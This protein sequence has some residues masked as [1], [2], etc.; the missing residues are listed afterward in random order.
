[1]RRIAAS[2]GVTVASRIATLSEYDRKVTEAAKSVSEA[3]AEAR[4]LRGTLLERSRAV[5]RINVVKES[6]LPGMWIE[7]WKDGKIV[8]RAWIDRV[9]DKVPAGKTIGEYVVDRLKMKGALVEAV[10]ILDISKLG[11]QGRGNEA[12]IE[13]FTLEVKFK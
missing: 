9:K 5:N 11:A 7:S 3:E 4:R 10:K 8:V 2:A 6:L 13:Q 1:M 12:Q